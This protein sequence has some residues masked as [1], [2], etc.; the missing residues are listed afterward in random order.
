VYADDLLKPWYDRLREELPDVHVFDC[1]TH[2]GLNDPS[3]FSS[4]FEQLLDS[5]ELVDAR[6]AVF[7]LKEPEGYRD[8]NVRMA[9]AARDS[10]GR[11]V[12]FARLDPAD[13]PVERA[14][15]ALAAGA[16]GLKLHPDGEEF[17]LADRRLEGVW[18]LANAE[19]LPI[20]VHAGPELDGVGDTVLGVVER[21]PD[22][23]LILAHAAV[24]DLAW[25][26]QRIEDHRNLF[27]DTSW[28]SA[29]DILA[30]LSV[31]PPGQVLNASDLPY[32]TPLSGAHMSLRCALQAG[33]SPEQIGLIAGGQFARLVA[34]AEPLDGGPPP[35]RGHAPVDP[36]LERVY[37][38][39]SAALEAM[40]RGDDAGQVL[41]L[42]RHAT[43]VPD[44]H[45]DRELMQSIAE[46]LELYSRHR[47]SLA[48]GNQYAPG[49]DLIAAG[50]L[51][52]RTPAAPVPAP[53]SVAS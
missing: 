16:C 19:R 29:S 51:L 41:V 13:E 21:Y 1:H 9:Q 46:L 18:E 38:Y 34:R 47:D 4:T 3:G 22:L 7:A 15:Q 39:L 44:D 32:C 40:Q 28:W 27:F 33:L 50:A 26:W 10:G 8:A 42:A 6:A 37:V 45:P 20:V 43:K 49:W 30:L 53:A 23:R 52:A 5:L 35:P 12:A 36:L 17:D 2:V 31:I 48:T 24:T 11:M 25:I 14:E